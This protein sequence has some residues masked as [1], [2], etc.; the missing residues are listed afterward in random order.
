MGAAVETKVSRVSVA[1]AVCCVRL[2]VIHQTV[3]SELSP[4]TAASVLCLFYSVF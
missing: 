3:V 4:Q 1:V 2:A